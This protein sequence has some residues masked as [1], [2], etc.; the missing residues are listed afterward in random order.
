MDD[1]KLIVKKEEELQKQIKIVKIFSDDIHMEFGLEKYIKIAFKRGKIVHLQNLVIDNNREIQ[2]LEQG[3]T[4]KYLR[5]EESEGIQIETGIQQ[6]IK[7]DT[8]I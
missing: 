7:N 4:Y 2:E 6:E 3:K 5:I 1:L 8:E